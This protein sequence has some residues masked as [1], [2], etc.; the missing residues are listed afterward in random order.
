MPTQS[1][2]RHYN[3]FLEE[4]F[5]VS[6]QIYFRN[7]ITLR[8]HDRPHISFHFIDDD[9]DGEMRQCVDCDAPT[10]TYCDKCDE[11]PYC[12][13]CFQNVHSI[14]NVLKQHKLVAFDELQVL[15]D[16]AKHNFIS[17]EYFCVDCNESICKEC[18]RSHVNHAVTSIALQV[19]FH[20][21]IFQLPFVV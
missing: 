18:R 5:Y 21:T 19:D 15:G 11:A 1:H 3:Q 9:T 7:F 20:S 17:K 14:G 4:N 12:S 10:S 2:F 6:G 16:C 8:E 13:K